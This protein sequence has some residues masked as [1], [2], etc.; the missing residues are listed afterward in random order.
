MASKVHY[1]SFS[2]SR[3]ALEAVDLLL[4][5]S[6]GSGNLKGKR[7]AVKTH[8]GELGNYTHVRPQF[9]RRVADFVRTEGGMPFATDTTTL[10]PTGNRLEV[11]D[12]LSSAKYNGFTEEGLGCPIVVA[13]EPDGEGGIDVELEEVEEGNALRRIRVAK[14]IADAD[15]MLVVSHVKGHPIAGFG[16]AIKNLGMGCTTKGCKA[17]QHGQHGIVFNRDRCTMCGKCIEV[18]R[19]GALEM[20]AD[21]PVKDESRCLHC[22]TCMFECDAHA[23]SHLP[24]GKMLFQEGLAKAAAGVSR[25]M[26]S[27]PVAYINFLLDVTQFCDC[28]APAG[29]LV[30]QNIGILASKDPV[31]VDKASLDLLDR[32]TIIPGWRKR[33]PDI[34]GKLNKTDSAFHLKAAERLH[35]GSTEYELIEI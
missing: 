16:G 1:A 27:K 12:V 20:G 13:D 24:N 30:F 4:K 34:L 9:V 19:F 6:I 2:K 15:A 11:A 18:C 7:T 25:A 26:S 8:F 32:A 22:S 33:G 29:L 35:T 21:G 14:R 28:A 10:Y 3:D 17:A 5:A 31:A 23:I